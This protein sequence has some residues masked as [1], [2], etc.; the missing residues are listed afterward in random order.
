MSE[1]MPIS[2]EQCLIVEIFRSLPINTLITKKQIINR[3]KDD[4]GTFVNDSKARKYIA[5]IKKN[6]KE[7]M[8]ISSDKGYQVT[9]DPREKIKELNE[10]VKIHDKIIKEC[11]D[12][13]LYYKKVLRTI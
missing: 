10:T 8:I 11:T 1:L 12:D 6:N 3:L 5:D 2:V 13:I 4:H 9:D 7:L